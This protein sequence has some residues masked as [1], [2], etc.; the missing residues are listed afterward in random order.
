MNAIAQR[1]IEL[2]DKINAQSTQQLIDCAL[3]LKDNIEES[4]N[5]VME[6]ITNEL[7]DRMPEDDFVELMNFLEGSEEIR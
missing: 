4:A 2:I 7:M 5:L 1:R 3:L 6:Y